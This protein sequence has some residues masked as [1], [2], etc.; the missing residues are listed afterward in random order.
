MEKIRVTHNAVTSFRRGLAPAT[1]VTG[2]Y[3]ELYRACE[4]A[5]YS[6]TPPSWLRSAR[7]DND[8]YLL[9]SGERAALPLRRG[10]AVACLVN[11][12]R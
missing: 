12:A 2:A 9:L 11:P 1:S 3:R 6:R 5:R 4:S 7:R 10:R 8:G